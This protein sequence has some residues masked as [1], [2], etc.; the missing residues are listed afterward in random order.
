[1]KNTYALAT[2]ALVA[3]VMGMSAFAPTV[4]ASPPMS[5]HL[6]YDICHY[7]EEET[8]EEVVI[9]A[10]WA[11]I[12]VDNKGMLKG[13]FD[14]DGLARHY[15]ASPEDGDFLVLD[16]DEGVTAALCAAKIATNP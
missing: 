8:V 1:M 3:V 5:E 15:E 10:H 7:E 13:H 2:I 6:K 9:P 11:L 12:D 16:D 4:M 14:K